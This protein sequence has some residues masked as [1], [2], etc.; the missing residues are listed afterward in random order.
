MPYLKQKLDQVFEDLKYREDT[1]PRQASTLD[2][3]CDQT[4]EPMMKEKTIGLSRGV[5]RGPGWSLGMD[6]FTWRD[7]V[8]GEGEGGGAGK[9]GVSYESSLSSGAP[10]GGVP[11]TQKLRT[12]L[13]GTPGC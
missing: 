6:L 9:Y 13:L 7:V 3:E 12:P 4:V 2:L 8:G 1:L 5:S 11:W 10:H